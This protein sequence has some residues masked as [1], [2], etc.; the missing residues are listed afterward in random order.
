LVVEVEV[1]I[2]LLAEEAEAEAA[3]VIKTIL[4]LHQVLDIQ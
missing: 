3:S 4:L 2:M 1:A